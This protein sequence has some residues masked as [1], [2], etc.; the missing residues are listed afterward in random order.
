MEATMSL[1]EKIYLSMVLFL[2]F[3]FMALMGTISWLDGKDARIQ[4]RREKASK[5]AAKPADYHGTG[6]AHQH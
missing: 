2:F 6:T 1:A 5:A 3:G 4:R